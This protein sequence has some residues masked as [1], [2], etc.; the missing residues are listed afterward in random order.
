M[1]PLYCLYL[2]CLFFSFLIGFINRKALKS[3]QLSLLIPYLFLVFIQ[4]L[5]IFIIRETYAK[6][7]VVIVYNIYRPIT[8]CVFAWLYYHFP[9]RQ[10]YRKIIPWIVI[11]Y[12]VIV[13]SFFLFVSSIKSYNRELSL[14]GGI[15]LTLFGILFLFDYFNLDNA[16]EEDKWRPVLWITAGIVIFYPVVNICF[17]FYNDIFAKNAMIFG[18]YLYNA[19]PQ[20]LSIIMY[21]SFAF[22]FYLCR[23]NYY[24]A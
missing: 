17:A 12:L 18:V 11:I 10:F 4:E 21:G 7:D 5:T 1:I 6:P 20:I 3:R 23:K 14:G 24:S 13:A 19:I 9:F 8:V 2:G 16:T 15:A 22:A